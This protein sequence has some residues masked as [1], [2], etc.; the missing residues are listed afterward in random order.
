MM[1]RSFEQFPPMKTSL[2][3]LNSAQKASSG[4]YYFLHIVNFLFYLA[5]VIYH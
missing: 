1:E 5:S 4:K 2:I 3:T